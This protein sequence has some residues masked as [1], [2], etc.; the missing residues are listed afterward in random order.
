MCYA[1]VEGSLR[2]IFYATHHPQQTLAHCPLSFMQQKYQFEPLTSQGTRVNIYI[3]M[4][5]WMPAKQDNVSMQVFFSGTHSQTSDFRRIQ[6]FPTSEPIFNT[7]KP[8][9]LAL[10]LYSKHYHILSFENAG[11]WPKPSLR[12]FCLFTEPFDSCVCLK[13]VSEGFEYKIQ[14]SPFQSSVVVRVNAL[15]SRCS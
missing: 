6:S 15:V 14:L 1:F 7:T 10:C 9:A 12:A 8:C 2:M 11:A 5:S 3:T 4:Y 13:A